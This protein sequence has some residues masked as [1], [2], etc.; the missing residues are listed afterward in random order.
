MQRWLSYGIELDNAVI[1][2]GRPATFGFHLCRGNQLSRWLVAGGYEP[3][4]GPVF[5][6]VRADRLLLEYDD[7]RSG[8]FDALSLVPDDKV[9]VLGL[10]TTKTSR[11]EDE[12]VVAARVREAARRVGAERL[13][14]S[15]QCGFATSSAG[16]AITPEAQR[17]KLALLVRIARDVLGG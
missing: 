17:A 10:V 8:T 2:A 1:E 11:L 3:I 6:G 13:A 9:V 7:E 16:N 5:G 4:A 14:V 12:D 15:P